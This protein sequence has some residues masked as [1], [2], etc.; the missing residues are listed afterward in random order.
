MLTR[1]AHAQGVVAALMARGVACH[2]VTG[3]NAR[4]AAAVAAAVGIPQAHVCAGV[5]PAGKAAAVA[6]LRANAGSAAAAAAARGERRPPGASVA[7]VGDGTNDAP[8]LAAADVG[9]AIGA[10]TDVAVEAAHYVLMRNDLHDVVTALDLSAAALRRIRANYA[11]RV[12]R[13]AA[14]WQH[15]RVR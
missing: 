13:C 5:P 10:G 15:T 11:W 9:M 1:D 2:M 3:D 14:A 8:A 12:L 7:F 4:T 6:A